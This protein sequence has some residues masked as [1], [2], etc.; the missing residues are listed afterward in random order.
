[1]KCA[2]RSRYQ[3]DDKHY[4][5]KTPLHYL[6][7]ARQ[8]EIAELE[9]LGSACDLVSRMSQLVHVLQKERGLSNIFLAS[10]GAQGREALDQHQPR[11]QQAVAELSA[12]LEAF[13]IGVSGG[14][15]ARLFNA[16]AYVLQGIEALPLL[17]AH[18]DKQRLT[19]EESTRAYM[20][21]VAG[22]LSVVFEAAD[23]ACDPD[24]ARTLVAMFHFMQ[25][26]ELTGQERAAGAAAFAGGACSA[27]RQHHWLH[28]IESQDKCFQV[29]ADFASQA[30]ADSWQTQ[31]QS[32]AD[33]A[34]IERLRRIACTSPAGSTLDWALNGVWFE[35]C[36]LRLD[37]MHQIE[38]QLAQELEILSGQKLALA[39]A[40]LTQQL[41]LLDSPPEPV[42]GPAAGQAVDGMQF[43]NGPA[44]GVPWPVEMGYGPQLG[45]SILSLVQEQAQRL[46]L[47]QT[48]IDK[49]RT[50]LK[51]RKTIEQAKGVL[52]SYRQM[53]ESDAYKLIRQTAMNQNRRMLEVAEAVLATVELLPAGT[54]TKP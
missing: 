49:A 3:H 38:A 26:K 41:Q 31:N 20:R 51:E 16:I 43:F 17:R 15:G 47:M 2:A 8:N 12:T 50:S 4:P 27:A 48:E 21:L 18:R 5:M 42:P 36:S 10:E 44:Q 9:Q 6:V 28:L 35:A 34:V 40:S 53:S 24:I 11:V 13:S 33:M 23:S 39:R 25:G 29:F 1:M 14:H 32:C 52:M 37:A 54:G 7:S 45:R 19:P 46:H 22:C 30:V